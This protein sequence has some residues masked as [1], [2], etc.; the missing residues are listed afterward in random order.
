MAKKKSKKKAGLKPPPPV[1]AVSSAPSVEL[2]PDASR[3]L[4]VTSVSPRGFWRCGQH[5]TP[6]PLIVD[7]LGRDDVYEI[8]M[9][10]PNL[11]C[12][13]LGG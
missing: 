2:V 5:F 10:D 6:V 9:N 7:T 3:K 1:E 11:V 4:A 8:L 12:T 13:V